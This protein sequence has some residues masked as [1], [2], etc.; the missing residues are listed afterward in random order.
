M[1]LKA[2]EV[3]EIFSLI[4]QYYKSLGFKK[5]SYKAIP[6]I[7][8]NYPAEEDLYAL[9]RIDAQLIR[10]DISSVISLNDKIKFSESKKQSVTKCE[11]NNI[12]LLKI[13]I[14]KNI[15][16]GRGSFKI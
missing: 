1:S 2:V 4:K 7:Y 5:I 14:L 10:S 8:H 15:G 12:N 13:M 3:I 9:F 6:S 16:F 11:K